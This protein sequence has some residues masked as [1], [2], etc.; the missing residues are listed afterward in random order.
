MSVCARVQKHGY[1]AY[2]LVHGATEKM[3]CV[4]YAVMLILSYIFNF[5]RW[6][7]KNDKNIEHN[8]M[9]PK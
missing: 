1:F 8:I 3:I 7:S 4:V 6:V 5:L 9:E 2:W